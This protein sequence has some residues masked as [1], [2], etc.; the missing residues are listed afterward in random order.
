MEECV[1]VD[2]HVFRREDKN[3]YLSIHFICNMERIILSIA[4]EIFVT[5]FLIIP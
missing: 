4:V 3:K 5:A 1:K 2:P